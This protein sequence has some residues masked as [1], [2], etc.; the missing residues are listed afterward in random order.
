MQRAVKTMKYEWTNHG[1][2]S[3]GKAAPGTLWA[4][5]ALPCLYGHQATYNSVKDR[6][7]KRSYK[8]PGA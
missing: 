7:L 6:I 3:E 5:W 2:G 1:V 8:F 4:G